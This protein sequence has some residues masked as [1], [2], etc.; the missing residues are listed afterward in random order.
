MKKHLIKNKAA[1][2]I[3]INVLIFGF[4]AMIITG[5]R[6][7]NSGCHCKAERTL[8]LGQSEQAFQLVESGIEDTTGGI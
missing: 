6:L 4:I 1:G 5:L 8:Q 7:A 3:L 2:V